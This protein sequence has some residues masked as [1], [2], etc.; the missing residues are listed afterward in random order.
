M[1]LRGA[2]GDGAISFSGKDCFAEFILSL[3]KG[4]SETK[5]A[6]S[7]ALPG[8]ALTVRLCRS[9]RAQAEPGHERQQLDSRLRGND[10]P[11]DACC[12]CFLA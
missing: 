1:S 4:C 11:E 2:R 8:T 9:I 7:Q 3:P 10:G 5:P 6:P 12:F